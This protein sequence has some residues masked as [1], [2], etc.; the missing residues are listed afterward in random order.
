MPSKLLGNARSIT[1]PQVN[2]ATS[3]LGETAGNETV[4][5]RWIG[6]A[7]VNTVSAILRMLRLSTGSGQ[8][9]MALELRRRVDLTNCGF[10][11]L[12]ADRTQVGW[13]ATGSWDFTS[14]HDILP[15]TTESQDIGSVSKEVDNIFLQNAATVSD[16]RRK[17]DLGEIDGNQ[18]IAFIQAL[19]PKWFSYKDTVI[20]ARIEHVESEVPHPVTGKPM[21]HVEAVEHPERV[22][23]HSRPHAGFMAQQ[24]KQAM[25]DSGIADFAGYAYD[26]ESDTHLLRLMEMVGVIAAAVKHLAARFDEGQSLRAE[27][28][29]HA[30]A[31]HQAKEP[32]SLLPPDPSTA[33]LSDYGAVGE[34]EDDITP[35][36]LL[37][38][39][40]ANGDAVRD[41]IAKLTSE[42]RR[43]FTE[44]L[45]VELAELQ[46]VRGR[47]GEDLKR[48]AEIE[49]LLGLFARVGEM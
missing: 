37:N 2:T 25:T 42:K 39:M 41:V 7:G 13:D 9:T 28:A 24:F 48:E 1:Q 19:E 35:E 23:R 5:V 22:V 33:R 36:D 16:A 8:D 34:P 26:E 45:N 20:P 12:Q 40:R 4:H 43:R 49:K 44:L 47:A 10:L 32:A 15:V 18:A 38:D 3:A 11:R 17:N 46:Q 27:Q 14:G 31:E 6:T 21:R 30:L 29:E